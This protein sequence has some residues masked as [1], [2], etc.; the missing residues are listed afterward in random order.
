MYC[1]HKHFDHTGGVEPFLTR[2]PS[3][4]LLGSEQVT[5]AFNKFDDR[6]K[7]V[8]DGETFEF[9][10]NSLSFT[11][12]E[13]GV[14]KGIYNLA[15]E[16]RIGDF[17]FAH[18]G[19]AVSFEGFPSSTVDVLGGG[20]VFDMM[21]RDRISNAQHHVSNADANIRQARLLLGSVQVPTARIEMPSL[22]LDVFLDGLFGI[23]PSA[24]IPA[25]GSTARRACVV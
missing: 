1:T 3:A 5:E 13:H 4:I 15:V 12:L 8:R 24:D 19:D 11:R 21:E 7:T 20:F 18:C 10:S 25:T 9:S 14:F 17:I 6:V 22:V 16:I 2:N 23:N